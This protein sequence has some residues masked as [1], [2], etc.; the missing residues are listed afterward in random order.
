MPGRAAGA[1]VLAAAIS[2][3]AIGGEL[4]PGESGSSRGAAAAVLPT[5]EYRTAVAVLSSTAPTERLRRETR[6]REHGV[7]PTGRTVAGI[8]PPVVG[9]VRPTAVRVVQEHADES[10]LETV[11][12]CLKKGPSREPLKIRCN[13]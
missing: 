8:R 1:A 7:G 13:D 9:K 3:A 4:V 6:P 5:V 12:R 2:L 11:Q 10:L